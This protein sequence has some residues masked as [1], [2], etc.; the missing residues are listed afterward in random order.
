MDTIC[1]KIIWRI[2]FS[3]FFLLILAVSCKQPERKSSWVEDYDSFYSSVTDSLTA[4]P[5]KV[6]G[7]TL[8]KMQMSTDSLEWYYYA[9]IVLKTYMFSSDVDS[10]RHLRKKIEDFCDRQQPSPYIADLRSEYLNVK[11]NIYVRVGNMDSAII[12]FTDS[13]EQRLQGV[14]K[15]LVSDIL[16]NL[17][18]AC[19]RQGKYDVSAYWYRKALQTSDSL[20]LSEEKRPPVYYGLAQVYMALHDFDQCDYYY[21]LA[22]TFYDKMLPY[23]QYIYLNNRGN[24]YYYREDYTEALEYFKKGLSLAVFHSDMVFERN[25]CMVNLGDV[26]LQMNEPDS[27]AKYISKCQPFFQKM[28]AAGA[29]YYIDTQRIGLALERNDIAKVRHL[30]STITNSE[31]VEPDMLHIRNKYL[32]EFY[33]RTADY[34]NAFFYQ[35]ENRRLD[36]SIRNERVKMRTADISLR[37]QQD[38]TLLA[39]NILIE[40][41]KIEMLKLNEGLFFWIGVCVLVLIITCFIYLYG[42]KRRALLLAQSQRTISSLRLENIRNRISPHFIFN[43]LNQEMG[44][45]EGEK[46][47]ELSAL[48]KLMRRNLELAEQMCITL[49]EELEFVQTYIELQRRSLGPLFKLVV[50]VGEDVDTSQLILP[51]MLIQIPVENAVKHALL[52]KEGERCLWI[53]IYRSGTYV[54]VKITDNGGGFKLNSGN[55][56][57]GTGMKVIMQTIQ[58][59]NAKNKDMIETA[60]RNVT[61]PNG[62][63][64]CEVSF[65]LPSNY[66]YSVL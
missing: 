49:A 28:G 51:S 61:L 25:L 33:E 9:A 58:I 39:K 21:N 11:G 34:K 8:Q 60:V 41:Q 53:D 16:I 32:Q 46:K 38:S 65:H 24:S 64:G 1:D 35:K 20:G 15:E 47:K 66:D 40:Q 14:K 45:R 37:Y 63:T 10:A 12:C 50:K 42:K 54:C 30:L 23:E 48:V 22:E 6:R 13:Y 19:S 7:L 57:T 59:L 55:R 5:Q 17:A 3:I 29:L 4:Y 27:A 26:Y 36:D 43:V 56:G 44:S 52:N 2:I 62:E 18:D 31:N